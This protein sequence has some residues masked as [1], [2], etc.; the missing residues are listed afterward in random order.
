MTM[1]IKDFYLNT[2]M[3]RYEYVMI[4]VSLIPKAIFDQYKLGP[5]VHNGH[6]YV[7][8]RKGMYGLPQ[9]GQI[10]NDALVPYLALHGYHQCTHT[11]GLFKHSTC[12]V[13]F[14]LVVDDFGVQYVGCEN[15][16]HLANII[17]AKYKMTTDWM[18]NLYVGITLHW[19]YLHR[20]VDMSMPGY[21]AKALQ[22]F[23]IQAPNRP[24][25]SPFEW[26]E[27]TYG[28]HACPAHS[29]G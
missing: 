3:D 15:A 2:P 14:S 9:A 10:A 22:R 8:I 18:G 29:S 4:P 11:P 23:D 12:P 20:T 5:L 7:E 1:D 13:I 25:H 6:V 27:P 26:V 19:D 28:Q 17:A 24:Q 16:Q 21:V